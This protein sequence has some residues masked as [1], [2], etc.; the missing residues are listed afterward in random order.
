MSFVFAHVRLTLTAVG[1]ET[2]ADEF[3][4]GVAP[5]LGQYLGDRRGG[6]DEFDLRA[7]PLLGDDDSGESDVGLVAS[8]G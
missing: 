1:V 7:Q 2:I 5:L 6:A 8:A 4:D 3:L